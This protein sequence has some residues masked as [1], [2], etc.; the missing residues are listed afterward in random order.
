MTPTRLIHPATMLEFFRKSEGTWYT[1][2]QVHHFDCSDDE[3]GES[4]LI[5]KVL[6]ADA[7]EVIAICEQQH[8]NPDRAVGAA[9]FGWQGN[10]STKAFNEKYAAVLVDVPDEDNPQRGRLLRDRG[11]VEVVPVISRYNFSDDHVLTIDTDYDN[12]RGQER[13]WFVTDDVR[14]RVSNV[15]T[16]GGVN[17]MAYCSEFRC[18][19]DAILDEA[20]ARHAHH[21]QPS[22]TQSKA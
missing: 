22:P 17:L 3:S 1:Q 9:S 18:I 2:R 5:V 14:V 7:P 6:A 19:N 15:R 8:I 13:C 11:H 16:A 21:K 4:N 12:H 10:L 20:I